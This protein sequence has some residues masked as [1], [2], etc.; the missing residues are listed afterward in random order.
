V[1]GA[2]TRPARASSTFERN[3]AKLAAIVDRQR[4]SERT[5]LRLFFA[6]PIFYTL[7]EI[8]N[9]SQGIVSQ[10]TAPQKLR[11]CPS[12]CRYPGMYLGLPLG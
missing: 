1:K 6:Y 3:A 8:V 2:A 4:K 11:H 10:E 9:L 5:T 12:E 7:L